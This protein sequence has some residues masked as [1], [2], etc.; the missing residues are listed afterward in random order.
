MQ[1][2]VAIL[3]PLGR[4]Q[5]STR[6]DLAEVLIGVSSSSAPP[7]VRISSEAP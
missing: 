2:S 3:P 1:L 6:K 5:A 4:D 7:L